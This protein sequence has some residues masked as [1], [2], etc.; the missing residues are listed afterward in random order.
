MSLTPKKRN[1]QKTHYNTDNKVNKYR[2][3]FCVTLSRLP[4]SVTDDKPRPRHC[5]LVSF[6]YHEKKLITYKVCTATL[7][8]LNLVAP[9][10]AKSAPYPPCH[11]DRLPAKAPGLVNGWLRR[12]TLTYFIAGPLYVRF[13][14][15]VNYTTMT[16]TLHITQ[17]A[18]FSILCQDATAQARVWQPPPRHPTLLPNTCFFAYPDFSDSISFLDL[19]VTSPI[20]SILK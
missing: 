5:P 9:G 13:T 6:L 17:K 11:R 7:N 12:V 8:L 20:R 15:S 3:A 4:G 19:K 18:E 10:F 16:V 14:T 1:K 2:H